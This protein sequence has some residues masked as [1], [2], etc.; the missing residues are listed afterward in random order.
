MFFKR[1]S[2]FSV[3]IL[4]IML[5]VCAVTKT[6]FIFWY[7]KIIFGLDLNGGSSIT[8]NVDLEN[9]IKDEYAEILHSNV[10]L[11]DKTSSNKINE[12]L[13]ENEKSDESSKDYYLNK[14]EYTIDAHGIY[15]RQDKFGEVHKNDLLYVDKSYSKDYVHIFFAPE[16]AKQQNES[17]IRRSI[18]IIR[19]RIDPNSTKECHIYPEGNNSISVE[20]PGIYDPNELITLIGKTANLVFAFTESDES[21]AKK[22]Q[23]HGKDVLISNTPVLNGKYLVKADVV[24]DNA[25][26]PGIAFMF[27]TEGANLFSEITSKNIGKELAIILD[28]RILSIGRINTTLS[29]SGT[30]SG[31]FS[32]DEAKEIAI[33]MCSGAL[34]AKLIPMS[35]Y[36]IGPI[37]GQEA[38]IEGLNAALVSLILISIFMIYTYGL[39]GLISII[40]LIVNCFM[41]IAFIVMSES[42]LTLTGIAGIVATIGMAVDANILINERIKEHKHPQSNIAIIHGYQQAMSSIIDSNLTTLIGSGIMYL[43]SSGFIRGFAVTLSIGIIISMFTSIILSRTILGIFR[44]IDYRR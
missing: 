11:T 35:Q 13:Q 44:N 37:L 24:M 34:P 20:A 7:P 25:S 2:I 42:T 41:L 3:V 1:L 28:D 26:R 22:M 27:N 43:M 5:S 15:V 36:K 12:L 18:E 31:N 8:F 23:Y 17:I 21:N 14:P 19:T 16:Y 39:T 6:K 32:Y 9:S 33:L 40:S 30:I 29:Y 10:I 4:S 38:I